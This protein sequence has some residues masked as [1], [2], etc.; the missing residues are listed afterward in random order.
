MQIPLLLHPEPSVGEGA[1]ALCLRPP[2]S[3]PAPPRQLCFSA[4]SPPPAPSHP[5]T[6]EQCPGRANPPHPHPCILARPPPPCSLHPCKLDLP[7]VLPPCRQDPVIDDI[8]AQVNKVTT[9]IKSNN[10]KLK[11][12]I[13]KMANARN[14]CVDVVLIIILLSIGGYL[15]SVFAKK[16]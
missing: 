11:G 13:H 16:S 6:P 12:L 9:T 2:P 4:S 10:V 5:V 7:C 14:F 8:E 15:Y 1:Q 3:R